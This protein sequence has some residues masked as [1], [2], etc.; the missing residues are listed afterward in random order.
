MKLKYTF[1]YF[2]LTV[3]A[4][5][6]FNNETQAQDIHFSQYYASPITLNPAMTGL[7]DGCYRGAVNY[8]NQYPQLYKT[9]STVAASF[10]ASLLKNSGIIPGFIG[11][12]LWMYNDRQGDG[13]LNDF[14]IHGLA[15]YHL[16]LTGDGRY[17]FSFGSSFGWNQKSVDLSNLLFNEQQ[18]GQIL[19]ATL[20]NGESIPGQ[21]RFNNFN[22]SVGSSFSASITNDLGI[23]AGFG[24]FNLLTPEESFLGD[25]ENELGM[26]YV[27]HVSARYFLNDQVILTPRG[28]FMTQTGAATYI[29]GS[30]VGYVLTE[31][32]YGRNSR[33]SAIYGGLSYRWADAVILTAGFQI[34][35]LKMGLSYDINVS[36]LRRASNGIG[37]VEFS[38]VYE[39]RCYN[40]SRNMRGVPPVSCPRF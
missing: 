18:D 22:A 12:G 23:L 3:I 29:I 19:N 5:L 32:G 30:S 25:N 8:R 2:L 36:S 39:K 28:I 15:A 6:G 37:G 13:P 35:E 24:I 34:N 9:Y 20:P 27:A 26:R 4:F 1:A 16:D 31:K 11:V 14:A 33:N 21:Q 17:L 10:D 7:M 38:L 40:N